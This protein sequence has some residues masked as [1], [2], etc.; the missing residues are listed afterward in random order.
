MLDR[1]RQQQM[2]HKLCLAILMGLLSCGQ[3]RSNSA[4]ISK[5]AASKLTPINTPMQP[6][7]EL[8]TLYAKSDTV[9]HVKRLV[10]NDTS[11]YLLTYEVNASLPEQAHQTFI[12]KQP[13][14]PNEVDK[15]KAHNSSFNWKPFQAIPVLFV[16]LQYSIFK[17]QMAALNKRQQLEQLI[18]EE[19]RAKSMGHWIAG[20][21][22]PGGAN[23]LFEVQ[24]VEKAIGTILA[25]LTRQG[26]DKATLVGRRVN[27][28]ADDWFYEVVY[29]STYN[30]VFITM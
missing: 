27:V 4:K 25:I 26:L 30:G 14:N 22:G 10:S 16:Q 6:D 11:Y 8:W 24:S 28:T 1:C 5:D 12:D 20:D 3:Q 2:A 18:D 21:I 7:Q 17:D 23:M 13:V 15:I 29:P 19:L 9:Y